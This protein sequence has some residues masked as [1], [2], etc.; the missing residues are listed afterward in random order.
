MSIV[1]KKQKNMHPLGRGYNQVLVLKYVVVRCGI[2]FPIN[3]YIIH[4]FVIGVCS[5]RMIFYFLF[6]LFIELYSSASDDL[7]YK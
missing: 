6:F 1:L 7:P 2:C 3:F 4:I 5:T